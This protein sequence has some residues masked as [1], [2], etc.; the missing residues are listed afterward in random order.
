MLKRISFLI[1][2]IIIILIILLVPIVRSIVFII[3]I[4]ILLAL[5]LLFV[6]F[7]FSPIIYNID[8]KKDSSIV[9]NGKLTLFLG[10]LVVLF[11]F[12]KNLKLTT[13]FFGYT[14]KM[15]KRGISLNSKEGDISGSTIK[16]NKGEVKEE[17]GLKKQNKL[18]LESKINTSQSL[19]GESKEKD[20][21]ESVKKD[22]L[23]YEKQKDIIKEIKIL[24]DTINNFPNK[25][26]VLNLTKNYI[27]EVLK[28]IKPKSFNI[29]LEVGV[30]AYHTGLLLAALS[31]FFPQFSTYVVGNFNENLINGRVFAKSKI[32]VCSIIWS[33]IKFF[34]RKQIRLLTKEIIRG[35]IRHLRNYRKKEIY[36]ERYKQ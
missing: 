35:N 27:K 20:T 15:P 25:G 11:S 7:V 22:N 28:I 9:S 33:T 36:Y 17:D 29:Q 10:A 13:K 23:T 2:I 8:I 6:L 3:L 34:L 24:F 30:G 19:G 31:I 5:I 32:W 1:L 26:Q 16:E 18:N 12:D 21:N 14:T 4:T